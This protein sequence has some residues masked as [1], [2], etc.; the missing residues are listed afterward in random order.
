MP[1]RRRAL[2]SLLTVSVAALAVFA[3]FWRGGG[4]GG[5]TEPPPYVFTAR[6]AWVIDGDTVELDDGRR[7]RYVGIDTPE[8]D[9]PFCNAARRA[10]IELVGRGEVLVQVCRDEPRD[11]YGR[12]LGWVSVDGL[13]VGAELLGRGLARTLVIPPCGLERAG[14]YAA[15]ESGARS[16]GLGLWA[17][18][19]R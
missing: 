8:R 12:L 1:A 15:V 6:V 11:K 10:N 5:G 13:D 19:G 4:P 7:L 2:R 3:G 9:E 14:R 18:S 17:S 16:A